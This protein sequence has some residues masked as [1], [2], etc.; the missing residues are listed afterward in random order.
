[1]RSLL[2]RFGVKGDL[3]LQTVGALSGGEKT[4]VALARLAA[5]APNVLVLDE[6]TNHLDFWSSA[7]LERSLRE[8]AGTVL[9]VS[10]DRYFLDQV[11]TKVLVLDA[12]RC[13][14]YEGNYSD[15][16]HFLKA[17]AAPPVADARPLPSTMS[18]GVTEKA[19][20][21][22]SAERRRRRF[23]YRKVDEIEADITALE[24]RI[25]DLQAGMSDPA[26]L[27]D[28]ER[29]RQHKSEFDDAQAKLAQLLEHWEEASELN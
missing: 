18:P 13:R 28:G 8:F 21:G 3:G 12:Q 23:P 27:R 17:T 25:A 14:L 29:I 4:K 6:P 22:E 2:A 20:A 7:A 10:H 5:L 9:F 15:Y 11:A 1:M 19:A 16:Q 26:V 24:A